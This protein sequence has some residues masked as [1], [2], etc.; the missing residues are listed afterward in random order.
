VS[1][2]DPVKFANP[3][4]FVGAQHCYALAWKPIK[5]LA[6]NSSDYA[7]SLSGIDFSPCSAARSPFSTRGR[8]V[9]ER[10]VCCRATRGTA[11]ERKYKWCAGKARQGW[12]GCCAMHPGEIHRAKLNS[13]QRAGSAQ[14]WGIAYRFSLRRAAPARASR[15]LPSKSSVLGSGV[16]VPPSPDRGAISSKL[17][18]MNWSDVKLPPAPMSPVAS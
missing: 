3:Q 6:P 8:S 4:A 5:M 12:K 18:A 17:K 2:A 1:D 13:P 10:S 16:G 7:L 11:Y 9:C 14:S 15:P